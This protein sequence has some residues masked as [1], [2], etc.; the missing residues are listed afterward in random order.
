M[1]FMLSISKSIDVHFTKYQEFQAHQTLR[2]LTELWNDYITYS[3]HALESGSF[4]YN[5]FAFDK[6]IYGP[7]LKHEKPY[8][9]NISS[10]ARQAMFKQCHDAQVVRLKRDRRYRWPDRIVYRSW[11]K[12]PIK[13]YFFVKDGIRYLDESH[14]W[15]PIMHSVKIKE[16]GY[17]KDYD[18]QYIRSGR[19]VY[20]N[21]RNKWHIKIYLEVPDDYFIIHR[22]STKSV[23]P[24]IGLDIGIHNFLTYAMSDGSVGTINFNKIG[25]GNPCNDDY[26]KSR[27]EKITRLTRACSNKIEWNKHRL[28]YKTS[29]HK[30]AKDDI[31]LVYHSKAIKKLRYR[32]N[33][34]YG[35]ITRHKR[36]A[37]KKT[38]S[39]LAR[40]NP[41]FISIEN[42]DVV[43]LMRQRLRRMRRA[44]FHMDFG[45]FRTFIATKC[46]HYK[47]TLIEA[48]VDFASTKRCSCCGNKKKY[49]ALSNRVYKCKQCGL[50]IDRD[51]NAAINLLKVGYAT[52]K[53]PEINT[54]P[55]TIESFIRNFY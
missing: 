36:D 22:P 42:L 16:K 41:S 14:L 2:L 11:D 9:Q 31:D 6:E 8:Y 49:M 34:L 23:S 7:I 25:S 12:N 48:P 47:I 54:S 17:L 32:I 3:K 43:G 46:A 37:I 21:T 18:F 33:R 51:V 29:D 27:L 10:I 30:I 45:F 4:Q 20:D 52:I 1:I 19:I 44:M 15:I 26:V 50:S 55:E 38:C 35:E 53:K 40:S 28:G 5:Y 24:A 13:S 39:A